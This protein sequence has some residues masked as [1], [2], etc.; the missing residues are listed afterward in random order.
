MVRAVLADVL[1]GSRL[2]MGPVIVAALVT[3][4]VLLFAIILSIAWATDVFDG[5][6]ARSAGRPT[7]FGDTDMLIDTWV[8]VCVLLGFGLSERAP[9]WVVGVVIVLLGALY[10]ATRNPAVSQALQAIGYG[11]ALWLIFVSEEA[12]LAI[13]LGTLAVLMLLEY[14]KFFGKVLPM[15]FKG[16]IALARR[17]P[18]RGPST[19]A[20]TDDR[21][22]V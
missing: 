5:R 17:E 11:G 12:S 3:D 20:P 22:G 18:Y 19:D 6:L 10:L 16:V 21:T 9:L 15:F 14:K 2:V 7:L 1:T 4:R 8:G 13:P